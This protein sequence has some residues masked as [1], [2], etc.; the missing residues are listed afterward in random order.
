MATDTAV[1]V[2]YWQFPCVGAV[3][4]ILATLHS[5]LEHNTDWDTKDL[6]FE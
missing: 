4:Y 6:Q 2:A 5:K 1:F 3:K